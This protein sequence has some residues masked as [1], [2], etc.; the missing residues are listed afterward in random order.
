MSNTINLTLNRDDALTVHFALATQREKMHELHK[1]AVK[2]AID[3]LNADNIGLADFWVENAARIDRE[4]EMLY[5][6]D[7]Q[8]DDIISY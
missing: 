8:L 3:A 7:K 1:A 2:N 4:I 5:A 6:I